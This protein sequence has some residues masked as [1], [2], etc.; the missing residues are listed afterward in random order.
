MWEVLLPDGAHKY[1]MAEDLAP[2][3]DGL[4]FAPTEPG[5]G[6][7]IDFELIKRK[8]EAVLA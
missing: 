5:I 7:Q 1:G 8:T 2:D 3:K 6:G 4:M